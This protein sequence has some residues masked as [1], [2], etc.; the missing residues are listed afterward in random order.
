MDIII[1]KNLRK[2]RAERGNTQEELAAFLS[3]SPQAVSKWERGI[4]HS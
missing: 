4:S 2:L 1:D 3:V